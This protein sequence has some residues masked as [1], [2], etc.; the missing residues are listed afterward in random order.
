MINNNNDFF[1]LKM[2]KMEKKN[3]N[4]LKKMSYF[5]RK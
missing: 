3:I 5:Q 2:G 4:C 1:M